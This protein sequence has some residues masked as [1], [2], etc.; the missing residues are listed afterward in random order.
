MFGPFR[1]CKPRQ[2]L[3]LQSVA[4]S[5]ADPADAAQVF[6]EMP[7]LLVM[8]NRMIFVE[9]ENELVLPEHCLALVRTLIRQRAPH[10]QFFAFGSRVVGTVTDRRRV[11]RHSGL[12]LAFTGEPL[13]LEQL[14]ALRDAF[15]QSDLPMRVDIVRAGD[16]P[17]GWKMRARPL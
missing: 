16:L 2:Y 15:S 7:V 11:M 5:V 10:H 1:V 8:H 14:F 12:D 13:P 3:F 9:E 4:G 6:G 17:V